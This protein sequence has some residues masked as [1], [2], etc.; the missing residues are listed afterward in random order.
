[1]SSRYII[2]DF[3]SFTN[4]SGEDFWGDVAAGILPIAKST[5]KIL[6]NL[7]SKYVNEPLT[8]GVYGG[9]LDHGDLNDRKKAA[10]REFIEETGYK[11]IIKVHDAFLFK[12]SNGSFEYQNY[13][14]EI[15]S[16]FDPTYDWES[17]GH[18]WV[19]FD[20]LL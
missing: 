17:S 13:I 3:A 18:K 15:E 14:G 12:T 20:E 16:E 2:E 1:M 6:L 10:E 11:G 9:K 5:G 4:S 19:T 8:Y 7:R